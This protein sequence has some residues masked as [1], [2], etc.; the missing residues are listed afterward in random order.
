M[1]H[2]D[3][4]AKESSHPSSLPSGQPSSRSSSLPSTIPSMRLSL[5]VDQVVFLPRFLV[6][7]RRGSQPL[8][9]VPYRVDSLKFLSAQ[10]STIPI[11]LPS[12]QPSSRPSSLPSSQPSSDPTSL[13]SSLPLRD[14]Q[15]A[16][17]PVNPALYHHRSLLV[18][19]QP[20]RLHVHLANH[21]LLLP[22][23]QVDN[24]PP[25]QVVLLHGFQNLGVR[26]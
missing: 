19:Q 10:P 13:P 5:A 25:F 17:L 20:S 4:V 22:H 6:A 14:S 11:A 24:Q 12:G 8:F 3:V 21:R 26:L 15:A 16:S 18:N 7:N 9:R 23:N 1:A 2:T